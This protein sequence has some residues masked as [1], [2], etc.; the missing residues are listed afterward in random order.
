MDPVKGMDFIKALLNLFKTNINLK[1]AFRSFVNVS[2]TCSKTM[3]Y[4]V[5]LLIK[6]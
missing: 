6:K 3:H 2:C 4:I 1:N 5:S